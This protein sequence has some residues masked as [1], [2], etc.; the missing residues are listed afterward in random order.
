M[1]AQAVGDLAHDLAH[2][3]IDRGEL[4]RDA[5]MLDRA[6]IEQRHREID[7]VVR[8]LHVER[9]PFCQQSQ[10]ARTAPTYS[11]IHGPAGDQAM[12]KRRSICALTCVP[13]PSVKRPCDS[14]CKV[15]A[16]M[17]VTVGL[18]GKAMA[19]DVASFSLAGRLRGQRHDDEGIV[20]GLL[21]D[22]AV[23]A[24]LLQQ[25]G[26][27]ADA[28][29]IERNLGRAQAG[30]DLAERQESF[31]QHCVQY[32]ARSSIISVILSEAKDPWWQAMR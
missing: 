14:F 17:A 30:I 7:V 8:A 2:E 9:V 31:E 25:P 20:L 18:R 3:G 11:R 6:G 19:T 1:G 10:T 23:I 32:K 22:H 5:R 28:G 24:D 26:V 21:D 13:S 4:D 29:E 27:A 15:Q 16:L 12:P